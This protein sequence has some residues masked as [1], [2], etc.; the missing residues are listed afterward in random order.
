MRDYGQKNLDRIRERW[1][2]VRVGRQMVWL[3]QTASTN[4][5]ALDMAVAEAEPD[6]LVVLADYQM[7]GRG[8][9][10]RRWL[11]PC[12]ASVLCSVVVVEEEVGG[13]RGAGCGMREEEAGSGAGYTVETAGRLNLVA[14]VAACEAIAESTEL[15]AGIKWPNDLRIS[16][17]KVG[18]ILIESRSLDVVAGRP[19]ADMSGRFGGSMSGRLGGSLNGWSG[20]GANGRRVWVVG[21]GINCLQQA[22]HFPPELSNEAIS[23]EL[24]ASHP[25]DRIAVIRSLLMRLDFWLGSVDW[26]RDPRLHA[27]WESMAE[28]LGQRIVLRLQGQDYSGRTA[29]VDPIGGLTVRLDNGRQ[30]WFDPMLTSVVP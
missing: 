19:D 13:E 27:E 21:F 30:M 2:P 11:S 17:R 6:G 18:G 23:L 16:G 5:V 1:T 7:A 22:G 14:A 29:E 15:R 20:G 10:G 3:D 4:T 28:P 26:R 24:A 9:Q 12:G 8:R 25:V